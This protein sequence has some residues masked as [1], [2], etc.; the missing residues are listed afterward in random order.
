MF[1]SFS[2]FREILQNYSLT[3][4]DLNLRLAKKKSGIYP[5]QQE[6]VSEF[7]C[8]CVCLILT[9]PETIDPDVLKLLGM[10][11]HGVKNEDGFMAKKKSGFNQQFAGKSDKC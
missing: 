2:G 7:V 8:L 3:D 1:K 10:I 4:I 9:S 11:F 5:L 6:D